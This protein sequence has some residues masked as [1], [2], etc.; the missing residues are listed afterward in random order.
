[1]LYS[2]LLPQFRREV[3]ILRTLQHPN[4][5]RLEDVFETEDTLHVVTELATGGELFDFLTSHPNSVLTEAAVSH[6]IRQCISAVAYMHEHGVFHRDIKLENILLASKPPARGRAGGGA[7]AYSGIQLKIIDFGL[8]KSHP[9]N[10]GTPHTTKTFFGTA[11]YI[12]PEMLRRSAY[13]QAVDVWALGVVTFVLLCGVFPFNDSKTTRNQ[14]VDYSL[15]FPSWVADDVSD[16]AKDLLAHM[17]QV[18]PRRRI[19]AR[20]ALR[21]PWVAG[22]TAS[23]RHVL[24][25][26]GRFPTLRSPMPVLGGSRGR[27]ASFTGGEG[28][29]GAE[30]PMILEQVREEDVM[31]GTTSPT[32]VLEAPP[33]SRNER[34]REQR[35]RVQSR[36][37]PEPEPSSASSSS[38]DLTSLGS[39]SSSSL[40]SPSLG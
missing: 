20:D 9:G 1:M 40:G 33:T 6:L 35:H 30:R 2:E 14:R 31:H 32:P 19:S 17:L 21:H 25:S 13:T 8:S 24:S 18:D 4:I 5:I 36:I 34:R 11:G 15:K 27:G 3:E 28:E 37:S 16:S 39:S 23:P 10:T 38:E 12:A 29:K 26:P 22:Q 7:D